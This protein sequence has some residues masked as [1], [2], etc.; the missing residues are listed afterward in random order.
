M[1]LIRKNMENISN[2]YLVHH[3]ILGQKWGVRRYQNPDGTLTEAGRLKRNKYI[4]KELGNVEKRYEYGY[5]SGIYFLKKNPGS[6]D[7]K[8]NINDYKYELQQNK[9]TGDKVS[10]LK[11]KKKLQEEQIKLKLN[12]ELRNLEKERVSELSLDQISNENRKIAKDLTIKL[13]ATLLVNAIIPGPAIVVLKSPSTI[14]SEMRIS[15]WEREQILNNI[16]E[17][18]NNGKRKKEN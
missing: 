1:K 17:R 3:G 5:R 2:N 4:N 9:K 12:E 7:M 10:E 16:K 15:D 11:T 6:V 8:R 13:G 18:D 14:K